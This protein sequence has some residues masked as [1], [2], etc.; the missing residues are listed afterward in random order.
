MEKKVYI[1]GKQIKCTISFIVLVQPSKDQNRKNKRKLKRWSRGWLM[2]QW[3][4]DEDM[5]YIF[6]LTF[7]FGS[8]KPNRGDTRTYFSNLPIGSA[9][10]TE[11]KPKP[12]NLG[13]VLFPRAKA[14]AILKPFLK[15]VH[16]F[17]W[18]LVLKRSTLIPNYNVY[19]QS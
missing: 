11:S 10:I 14:D 17:A 7:L 3:L 9:L 2:L 13:S 18:V 19:G 6:W 1:L 12:I 16:I 8:T 4:D 5:V 15:K